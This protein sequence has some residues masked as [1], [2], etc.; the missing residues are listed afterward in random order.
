VA[1]AITSK[2]ITKSRS[3]IF[4]KNSTK[5]FEIYPKS[6]FNMDR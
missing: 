6:P 1:K 2:V 3:P 4:T 5:L